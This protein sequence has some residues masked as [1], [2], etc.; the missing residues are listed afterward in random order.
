MLLLL[1]SGMLERSSS[2]VVQGIGAQARER[3]GGGAAGLRRGRGGWGS[4]REEE[5]LGKH[6][7]TMMR[8]GV[9]WIEGCC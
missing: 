6:G 9:E 1:A 4:N 2:E 8:V 5:A 3:L 7:S